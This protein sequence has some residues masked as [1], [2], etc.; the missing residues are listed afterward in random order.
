[1]RFGGGVMRHQ[2]TE[3][4]IIFFIFKTLN[5]IVLEIIE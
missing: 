3:L 5:D 4:N 1:M 2:R